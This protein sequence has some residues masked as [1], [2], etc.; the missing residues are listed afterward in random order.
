MN[1]RCCIKRKWPLRVLIVV[2]VASAR[3][4]AEEAPETPVLTPREALG[5]MAPLRIVDGR[6]DIDWTSVGI[7]PAK[8]AGLVET[9]GTYSSQI[10]SVVKFNIALPAPAGATRATQSDFDIMLNIEGGTRKLQSLDAA[11][12]PG[13]IPIVANIS[14]KDPTG[15]LHGFLRARGVP[16]RGNADFDFSE[17]KLNLD[18][19]TCLL[20]YELNRQKREFNLRFKEER[21]LEYNLSITQSL[22]ILLIHF[23]NLNANGGF[24]F[25][26]KPHGEVEL[27]YDK[28]A[29]KAF[30]RGEN[31]RDAIQKHAAEIQMNFLRPL[32]DAGVQIALSI[33]LPVVMAAATTGF[34]EPLPEIAKKADALI[35]AIAI[36]ATA[37]ER[38][39]A[40][41]ELTRFY[42]QAI[43]HVFQASEKETNPDLKTVLK[44]VIAAHPGI[45][46]AVPF[47]LA[48]KIHEDRAYQFDL[49]EHA[50]LFKD[51]AR[52]RLAVLLGKD[53][54]D[55]PDA[56]KG[57]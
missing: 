22:N 3:L 13:E 23:E 27:S 14:E 9:N 42:P 31:L 4:R 56:W 30:V 40:V 34:S 26:Q 10:S 25:T 55:N 51:A 20:V 49:F 6:L 38:A 15:L 32:A 54:G 16:A 45:I 2:A 29:T 39:R 17:I 12:K 1:A 18:S 57:K 24:N 11:L 50:P 35:S 53:Y 37:E 21:V 41:T 43:Y 48:K 19:A 44:R 47:V 5:W 33:D 36:S 8:V 7:V 46:R 28:G 52:A